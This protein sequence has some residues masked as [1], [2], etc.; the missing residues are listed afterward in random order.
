MQLP[1]PFRKYFSLAE[2]NNELFLLMNCEDERMKLDINEVKWILQSQGLKP[3]DWNNVRT[4]EDNLPL[5]QYAKMPFKEP[6][7]CTP[8][9]VH[10]A[11][12]E[13]EQFRELMVITEL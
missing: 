6:Q 8:M 5:I 2:E 11:E 9:M 3:D 7:P 10:I 1:A 13:Y 12:E 4:D